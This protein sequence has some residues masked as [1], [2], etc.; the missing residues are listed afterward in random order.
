[1]MDEF[2]KGVG[3]VVALGALLAAIYALRL[4]FA[5]A[6]RSSRLISTA[7]TQREFFRD[8][9]RISELRVS[10]VYDED[11]FLN[12]KNQLIES[13][14]A[15]TI[16]KHNE[17]FLLLLGRHQSNSMLTPEDIKRIRGN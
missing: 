7:F 15:S 6:K 12:R 3:K 4:L 10:G 16:D 1:M 9:E 2:I 17:S 13:L 11:E 14:M 8:L 5:G